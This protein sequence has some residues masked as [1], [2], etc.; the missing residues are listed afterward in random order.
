MADTTVKDALKLF[1][2]QMDAKMKTGRIPLSKIG[3]PQHIFH[4]FDFPPVQGKMLGEHL[5]EA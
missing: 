3:F 5:L 2:R 4:R 1:C